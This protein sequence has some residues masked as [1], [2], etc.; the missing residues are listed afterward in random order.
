MPA[1]YLSM[2]YSDPRV[3]YWGTLKFIEKLR[4][5]ATDPKRMPHFGD[6]NIVCRINKDGGHFGSTQNDVNLM[7]IVN[8][9]A[10]L[11]F[12]MLNPDDDKSE[13]KVKFDT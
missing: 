5:L 10:W 9:F 3:P 2:Q 12:L 13:K 4:D 7:G 6:K 1:I 8:E 11:E